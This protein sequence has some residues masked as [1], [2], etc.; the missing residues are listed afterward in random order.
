MIF[1]VEVNDCDLPQ[2]IAADMRS[3]VQ[4]QPVFRSYAVL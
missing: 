4:N 3:R 2:V 1:P